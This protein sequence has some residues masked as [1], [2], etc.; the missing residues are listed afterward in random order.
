MRTQKQITEVEGVYIA[1]T[2]CG[3]SHELCVA[4]L[5]NIFMHITYIKS[6]TVGF[7]HVCVTAHRS[8]WHAE[9]YRG[10]L[11]GSMHECLH[12]ALLRA[13]GQTVRVA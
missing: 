8:R 7:G 1:I 4:F 10:H 12:R 11:H 9:M 6:Y 13:V 3:I 2:S 5:L